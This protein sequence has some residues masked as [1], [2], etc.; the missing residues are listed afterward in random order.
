MEIVDAEARKNINLL[1]EDIFTKA[2]GIVLETS[3]S[4]VSIDDAAEQPAIS[5]VS[6]IEPVQAGSGDPY[7]A[8]GG[9]N[10]LP[11]N[12]T[13][14]TINGVTFTVNVD[15]S[16]KVN[17]TSAADYVT[18]DVCKDLRLAQG[19]YKLLQ[20]N[21]SVSCV[22]NRYERSANAYSKFMASAGNTFNTADWDYSSYKYIVSLQIV[23]SGTTV[24]NATAYPMICLATETDSTYAP[25]SNI[26]PI[27]GWTGANLTR[28]GKNLLNLLD[29]TSSE[30]PDITTGKTANSLTYSGV[31]GTAWAANRYVLYLP[32]GSYTLSVAM[33]SDGGSPLLSVYN[34]ESISGSFAYVTQLSQSGSVSFDISGK[35]YIDLRPHFTRETGTNGENWTIRYYNIQLESGRTATTYEPYQ[36]STHTATFPQTVYGGSYDFVTGKL[37]A[38]RAMVTFDGTENWNKNTDN[39]IPRMSL[40]LREQPLVSNEGYQSCSHYKLTSWAIANNN[41]YYLAQVNGKTTC[42]IRDDTFADVVSFKAYLAAQYAAG[43][44]VQVCYELASPLT[45]DLTPQ[46]VDMLFGTNN[47]WSDTGDSKLVYIA[48]TKTYID[49]QIAAAVALL[50]N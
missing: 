16:V 10:L 44:P 46:Q 15:G 34:S 43:T 32:D 20:P 22:I 6:K 40:Q 39:P 47:V 41:S 4:L 37:T 28:C 5:A 26:R 19:E 14:Q 29:A 49:R 2:P 33:E 11:N 50:A 3:G 45:Y 18:L 42:Y 35:N 1:S 7:P 13:S 31:K 36:G 48:D 30:N 8:G 24:N 23:T 25:Y 27:S 12:A 9:K 17:G 21:N 38:D